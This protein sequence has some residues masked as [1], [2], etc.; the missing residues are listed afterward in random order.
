MAPGWEKEM[1]MQRRRDGCRK[2]K[3]IKRS[4][5]EERKKGRRQEWKEIQV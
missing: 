2:V 3:M 5:H 4:V 1:V